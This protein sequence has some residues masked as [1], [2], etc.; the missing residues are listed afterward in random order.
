MRE[1]AAGSTATL[2]IPRRVR[3]VSYVGLRGR[4]HRR[5]R[6]GRARHA[7]ALTAA[8]LEHDDVALTERD[9]SRATRRLFRMSAIAAKTRRSS[10]M[11]P[12]SSSTSRIVSSRRAVVIAGSKEISARPSD[13]GI[14]IT[15]VRSSSVRVGLTTMTALRPK[16]A[17]SAGA[18]G[19]RASCGC[20]RRTTTRLKSRS[21][22]D[23]ASMTC[24]GRVSVT[25][26]DGPRNLRGLP[27]RGATS[28]ISDAIS[29][30]LKHG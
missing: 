14:S 29:I 28:R 4:P 3:F 11:S 19:L 9:G 13:S 7:P 30:R 24:S 17:S 5:R 8:G 10:A 20:A 16:V 6:A 21:I 18:C 23:S 15:P 27:R 2:P 22:S 25:A 12:R 26:R 1:A